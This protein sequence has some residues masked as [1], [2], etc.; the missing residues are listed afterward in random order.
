MK[1]PYASVA[2]LLVVLHYVFTAATLSAKVSPLL[3]WSLALY[4]IVAG[5]L[6]ALWSKE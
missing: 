1:H 2:L 6:T 3:C 5:F 4:A